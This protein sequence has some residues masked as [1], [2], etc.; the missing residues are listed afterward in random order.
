MVHAKTVALAADAVAMVIAM[1][2]AFQLRQLVPAQQLDPPPLIHHVIV[3]GLSL[4]LWL[5]VFARYQLYRLPPITSRLREFEHVVHAFVVGL[6]GTAGLSL[7]VGRHVTRGWLVLSFVLG[8]GGVVL[9]RQ[10]V[11]RGLAA[12]RRQG[13]LLYPTVV[14]GTNAEALRLC[15]TLRIDP[16]L[17]YRVIGFVRESGQDPRAVEDLPVLGTTEDLLTVLISSGATQV[18]IATTAVDSDTINRLTRQLSD[19]GVRVELSSSLRDIR[20]ERLTVRS[21]GGC[22]VIDVQPVLR[23]GWRALAKRVF[24]VSV[25]AT[26]LVVLAPLLSAIAVLIRLDSAGPVLF[27]QERIGKDGELFGVRK[28]RTM[29]PNAEQLLA[30][31]LSLNEADGPLF[32][33]RHDPRVT[34]VGRILRAFSL[35]ELPQL[36]NVLRNDMSIV[37]PR[38]ALPGEV[39]AW[40]PE[41]HQRLRVKPG[42]TGIWQV[43][44]RT[45]APFSEYVRLDL[46]Y[47]DNWSLLTDLVIVAKTIPTVL[48]RKGGF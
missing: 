21:L 31:I 37:G 39:D 1:S 30:E 13:L 20:E 17:G 19:V 45:E 15:D 3:G 26:A 28:F 18:L 5:A 48:F 8:V 6:F 11:R 35:D 32:K 16:S 34:R 43:S 33:I 38:P 25:A 27:R 42:L 2:V 29:V 24:D 4:P 40:A 7:L 36:W 12:L 44:G 46:Y 41:L 9:E 10:L 14:V 23:H 47:I 22:P